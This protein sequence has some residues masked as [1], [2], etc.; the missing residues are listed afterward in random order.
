MSR[1]KLG[2]LTIKNWNDW[3]RVVRDPVTVGVMITQGVGYSAAAAGLAAGTIVAGFG[4]ALVGYLAVTAVT[5]WAIS[6]L[7]FNAKARF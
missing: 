7:C 1:Y 4:T 3:D 5:T 2:D 6:A